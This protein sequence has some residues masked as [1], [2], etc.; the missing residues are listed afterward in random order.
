ME[1]KN[2]TGLPSVSDIIGLYED[3]KWF[4]K[5]HSD[6]GNLVH[7][8]AHAK[9]KRLMT[10]RIPEHIE[11]YVVSF[12]EFLPHIKRVVLIEKRLTDDVKGF[13][14][15]IDL[16]AEMNKCRWF[17]QDS[18]WILDWK[19]AKA[20]GRLWKQRMAGYSRLARCNGYPHDGVATIRLRSEL[21]KNTLVDKWNGLPLREATGDF[22]AA[23]RVYHNITDKGKIFAQ[24]EDTNDGY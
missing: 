10:P 4:R 12:T 15:Q 21:G 1:Y 7:E 3:T 9:L 19:T 20:K 13:C 11:P 18:M 5:E 16:L 17:D 14:G 22:L 24:T 8:Y 23:T 2:E 6:R